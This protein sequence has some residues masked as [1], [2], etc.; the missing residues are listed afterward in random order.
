VFASRIPFKGLRDHPKDVPIY[1]SRVAFIVGAPIIWLFA[2]CIH[3][4]TVELLLSSLAPC[5]D[6]IFSTA[7]AIQLVVE[8]APPEYDRFLLQD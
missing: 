7:F 3:H 6:V 5:L 2:N 1:A 8:D 4:E